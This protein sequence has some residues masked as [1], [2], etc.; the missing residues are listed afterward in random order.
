MDYLPYEAELIEHPHFPKL[1]TPP[2]FPKLA[3]KKFRFNLGNAILQLFD[4]QH[5]LHETSNDFIPTHSHPYYQC[6]YYL[7]GCGY[8]KVDGKSIQIQPGQL[9]ILD[10]NV[11]HNYTGRMDLPTET[12]TITFDISPLPPDEAEAPIEPSEGLSVDDLD[13]ILNAAQSPSSFIFHQYQRELLSQTVK[14]IT[15]ELVLKQPGYLII[16]R[17]NL[18]RLYSYFIRFAKEALIFRGTSS[19]RDLRLHSIIQKAMG[20]IEEN[21]YKPLSI[22]DIAASCAICSSHLNV[23]FKKETGTTVYQYLIDIRM[24]KAKE[25]LR[26]GAGNITEVAFKVGF[27]DSNYFSR[28]FKMRVGISPREYLNQLDRESRN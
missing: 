23:L 12:F 28:M 18:L 7:R 22:E 21:Y 2:G 24:K 15:S 19:T 14:E 27:N 6:I 3:A 25:L 10:K 11:P 13:E 26:S 17:A 8:L 9:L 5:N 4:I 1:K 16:V 20:L